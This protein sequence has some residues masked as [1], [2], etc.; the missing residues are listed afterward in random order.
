[1]IC[2]IDRNGQQIDST[3]KYVMALDNLSAK[4]F[5]FNWEVLEM[6]GN[7]IDSVIAGFEKVKTFVGK[8]KPIVI[9]M[10]TV[11]GKGVDFMEGNHEW[12]GVAPSDSQLQKALEQLPVTL[13]DY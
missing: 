5:A 2:T 11:M 9:I 3:T 4:F 6:E 10:H 8:G 13:G 12:H 7:D 1:M